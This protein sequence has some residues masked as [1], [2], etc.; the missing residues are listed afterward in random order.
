MYETI[1]KEE[2]NSCAFFN[3]TIIQ[4]RVCDQESNFAIK[5]ILSTFEAHKEKDIFLAPYLQE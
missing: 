5:H 4:E 1:I 2:S 3:P